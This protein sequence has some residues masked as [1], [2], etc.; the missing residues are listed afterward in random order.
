MYIPK[1]GQEYEFLTKGDDI[2][3]NAVTCRHFNVFLT[4]KKTLQI[5]VI[6]TLK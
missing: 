4:L 5:K 1:A 2:N 3:M 6:K